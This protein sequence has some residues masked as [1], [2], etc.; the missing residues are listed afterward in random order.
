ML[1]LN[2]KSIK[3]K[4]IREEFLNF[5]NWRTLLNLVVLIPSSIIWYRLK[6]VI[7]N[8][9]LYLC[10]RSLTTIFFIIETYLSTQFDMETFAITTCMHP[11]TYLNKMLFGS[12]Q[13]KLQLWNIRTK[14]VK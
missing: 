1:L 14:Y 7:N 3:K 11:S 12:K 10:I 8:N 6:L 9:I 2:S 5:K 4:E 13:G